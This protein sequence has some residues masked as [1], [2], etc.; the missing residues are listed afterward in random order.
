MSLKSQI[1]NF[2]LAAQYLRPMLIPLNILVMVVELL[3]G[4]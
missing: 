3:F 4:S 2:L 1:V